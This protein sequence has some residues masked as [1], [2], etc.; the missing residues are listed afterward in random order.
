MGK[1]LLGLSVK[2]KKGELQPMQLTLST[3]TLSRNE[4]IR[5][6]AL[7]T[8]KLYHAIL[9]LLQILNPVTFAAFASL[10]A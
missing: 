9:P 5:L 10:N 6:N 7:L 8:P 2:Y 4:P 3:F 1:S